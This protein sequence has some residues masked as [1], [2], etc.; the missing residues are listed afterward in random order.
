MLA[1]RQLPATKTHR[2][3]WYSAKPAPEGRYSLVIGQAKTET[4]RESVDEYLIEED[5]VDT[6]KEVRTFFVAK[7]SDW[8]EI[9][10]VRV[11]RYTHCTCQGHST[12]RTCKH[13]DA[14]LDLTC[15]PVEEDV[16]V[17]VWP[18][19]EQIQDDSAWDF[20]YRPPIGL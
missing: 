5:H 6:P 19:A 8:S 17:S 4:S 1:K 15:H 2:C 18:S 7:Q 20:G 13:V 3:R 11:G 16:P 12:H 9:Y 10:R 14:V